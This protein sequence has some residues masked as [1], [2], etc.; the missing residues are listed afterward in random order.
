MSNSAVKYGPCTE[1]ENRLYGEDQIWSQKGTGVDNAPP[2]DLHSDRALSLEKKARDQIPRG[3]AADEWV[4]LAHKIV[5]KRV[6]SSKLEVVSQR[7]SKE[8]FAKSYTSRNSDSDTLCTKKQIRRIPML[9]SLSVVSALYQ[10]CPSHRQRTK[11][12]ARER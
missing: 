10:L 4:V 2:Q 11:P 9:P 7:T 1:S 6:L 3:I 5:E 8:R 12:T